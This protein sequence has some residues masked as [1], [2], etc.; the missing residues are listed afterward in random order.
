[1]VKEEESF[2]LHKYLYAEPLPPNLPKSMIVVCFIPGFEV[3]SRKKILV[4][5]SDTANEVKEKCFSKFLRDK[6]FANKKS[7]EFIL[8]VR[9][10]QDFLF[11][12]EQMME[13]DYVRRCICKNEGE[14]LSLHTLSFGITNFEIIKFQKSNSL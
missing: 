10:Y 7:S 8:K 12:N 14:K 13:Y 1:M 11:G 2:M 4:K 6:R 3:N 9:G 5:V